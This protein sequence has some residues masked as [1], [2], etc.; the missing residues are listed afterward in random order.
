LATEHSL[1]EFVLILPSLLHGHRLVEP[2][3]DGRRSVDLPF[4]RR[5]D[6]GQNGQM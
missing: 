2:A 5:S 3:A 1:A 4:S 6:E